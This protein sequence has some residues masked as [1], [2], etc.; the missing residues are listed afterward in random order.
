M[1]N[2]MYMD[3]V[4]TQH[5]IFHGMIT[6]VTAPGLMGDLTVLPGHS[7]LISILKLGALHFTTSKGVDQMLFIS[8]G[9]LEVQP[10]LVTI[11]ADTILRS[12]EEDAQAAKEAI[13]RAR[14]EIKKVKQGTWEYAEL[15]REI[16]ILR[17]LIE[18]SKVKTKMQMKRY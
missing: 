13:E 3:V 2:T 7:Q 15:Q 10:T 1:G 16:Q 6:K 5:E 11:L 4:D 12:D 18:M 8:G 9:I 14:G 17:A